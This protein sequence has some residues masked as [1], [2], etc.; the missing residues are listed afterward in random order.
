MLLCYIFIYFFNFVFLYFILKFMRKAGKRLEN[1][2]QRPEGAKIQIYALNNKK[3]AYCKVMKRRAWNFLLQV[4][5]LLLNF[6][7]TNITSFV[8][9]FNY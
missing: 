9:I 4:A 7:P 5:S 6:M 2:M 8:F 3:M 1:Q